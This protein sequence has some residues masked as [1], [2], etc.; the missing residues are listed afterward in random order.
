MM[1]AALLLAT[2]QTAA[3]PPAEPP[4]EKIICRTD[5]E[6]G[7]LI[8]K[9]KTCRTRKQW[10]AAYNTAR[11]TTEEMRAPRGWAVPQ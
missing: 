6:T 11:E 1:L 5:I 4:K 10:E 2:G 8:K 3:T 9:R 7:S